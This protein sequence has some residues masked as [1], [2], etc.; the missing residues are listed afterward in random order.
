MIAD[1]RLPTRRPAAVRGGVD[2]PLGQRGLDLC[3]RL[4]Y[5]RLIRGGTGVQIG[6][7]QSAGP[8]E[9]RKRARAGLFIR[10]F[11]ADHLADDRFYRVKMIDRP[12]VFT[13]GPL[14]LISVG[15]VV[16]RAEIVRL[17][18]NKRLVPIGRRADQT[19]VV[20]AQGR[21]LMIQ[22]F[23]GA[24]AGA[25]AVFRHVIVQIVAVQR[26]RGGRIGLIRRGQLSGAACGRVVDRLIVFTPKT[27]VLSGIGPAFFQEGL[28]SGQKLLIPSVVDI[29]SVLTGGVVLI[30]HLG[31]GQRV[32]LGRFGEVHIV[33][34]GDPA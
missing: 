28:I 15:S 13:G 26:R 29:P 23:D 4:S 16:D 1:D 5:G 8:G 7:R 10:L 30:L 31:I 17:D 18:L 14:G 3:P 11:G 34:T 20:G 32:G 21:Q 2:A 27:R 12:A 19:G 24:R 22:T 6:L 25:V 9:E 33:L